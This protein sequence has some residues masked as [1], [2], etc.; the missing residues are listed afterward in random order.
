MTD[1][2]RRFC[3]WRTTEPCPWGFTDRE[4]VLL[5]LLA[6]GLSDRR[7]GEA[8]H[9]APYTVSHELHRISR[10]LGREHNRVALAVWATANGYAPQDG[11]APAFSGEDTAV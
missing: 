6:R 4:K 10:L 2:A 9:L 11:D 7:I 3:R 8:V 1:A 5:R